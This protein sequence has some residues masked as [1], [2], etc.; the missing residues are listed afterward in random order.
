M[1]QGPE[2]GMEEGGGDL[3]LGFGSGGYLGEHGYCGAGKRYGVCRGQ[4]ETAGALES[5]DT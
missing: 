5:T 2:V 1:G 3:S 4:L